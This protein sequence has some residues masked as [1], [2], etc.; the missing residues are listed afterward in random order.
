[1]SRTTKKIVYG[2]AYACVWVGIFY[3]FYTAFI[4]PVPLCTDNVKNGDETS[5]DCG[6]PNCISCE[7]KNLP[8]IATLPVKMLLGADDAHS[9]AVL[10]LRNPNSTYG[11]PDFSYL[12][13][14]IPKAGST[15]QPYV[16]QVELPMYPSELK[17]RIS[18]TV[19]IPLSQ[20][21]KV[22]VTVGGVATNWRP[23]AEFAK[24]K[25]PT[26]DIVSIVTTNRI[27]INGFV[28]N[29]NPFALRHVMVNVL[30]EDATGGP[31][32]ASKTILNDMLSAQE[33]GFQVVAPLPAG[34]TE[35]MLGQPRVVV[36]GER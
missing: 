29:D 4:R 16:E 31:V 19:P 1:M 3:G 33:R 6:G 2:A 25:L 18:T 14:I 7:L 21:D 5:V 24:P 28:R 36:D 23:V 22:T 30:F 32:S 11:L 20:I 34:Y 10:E 8:A 17:Y 9:T 35:A 27:V 15:A 12:L 13:S 26:R